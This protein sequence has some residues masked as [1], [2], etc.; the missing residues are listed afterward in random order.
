[1]ISVNIEILEEAPS[2]FVNHDYDSMVV[3]DGKLHMANSSGVDVLDES[4]TDN[5]DEIEA[6]AKFP[7]NDLGTGR[8]KRLRKG[9]LTYEAYG[10]GL[11]VGV[12]FDE[13]LS[14]TEDLRPTNGVQE[15]GVFFGQRIGKGSTIGLKFSNVDGADF[16]FSALEITPVIL[17]TKP[18]GS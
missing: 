7:N 9:Y 17:H 16:S 6:Y 4:G 8:Q 14:Y 15:T 11:E 13:A 1:M 10:S 12:F 2:Q 5:G 18:R 3:F